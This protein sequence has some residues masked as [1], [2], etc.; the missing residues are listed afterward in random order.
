MPEPPNSEHPPPPLP[1]IP[2]AM[3]AAGTQAGTR[4]AGRALTTRGTQTRAPL[5]TR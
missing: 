3:K 2:E 4:P 1:P 5:K